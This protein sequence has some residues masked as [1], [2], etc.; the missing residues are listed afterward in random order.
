MR[1]PKL[2][3]GIAVFSLITI[4]HAAPTAGL[5]ADYPL[6]GNAK[7]KTGSGHNG[8]VS[9]AVPAPDRFGNPTG[10]LRFNGVDSVVTIP[11]LASLDPAELTL[12]AW[13]KPLAAPSTWGPIITKWRGYSQ[14]LD[15]F[16]LTFQP[17]LHLGFANGRHGMGYGSQP[18]HCYL[19]STNCLVLERWYHV[20]ATLD[21]AG[22][23]RIWI[24]G[25]QCG[26]DNILPLRASGPAPVHGRS[27]LPSGTRWSRA[28]LPEES[29]TPEPVRIGQMI[30]N[31]GRILETFNG[32]IDDVRVYTRA[33]SG[34]EVRAL[35]H[36]E[37]AKSGPSPASGGAPLVTVNLR[38]GSRVVGTLL[39]DPLAFRSEVLGDFKLPAARILSLEWPQQDE[40]PARLKAINGDELLVK[41][42]THELRLKT[43]FGELKFSPALVRQLQLGPASAASDP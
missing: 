26:E 11:S 20:V 19:Q 23:G 42:V 31:D 22:T 36:S 7:D 17:D 43:S 32:L 6:D 27:G 4:C 35:Y 13:I 37:V 28:E 14:F 3:W 21:A 39:T 10:A 33:L 1:M 15:Q 16:H 30:A 41:L 34:A 38:D 5:V 29:T 40:A 9:G 24:D 2:I 25:A 8:V 12:S 18:N